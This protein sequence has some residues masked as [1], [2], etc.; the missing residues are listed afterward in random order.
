MDKINVCFEGSDDNDLDIH[1]ASLWCDAQGFF[2][3]IFRSY[4]I[5]EKILKGE[6]RFRVFRKMDGLG[7]FGYIL[8]LSDRD[9][10]NILDE[11]S[12]IANEWELDEN[13]LAQLIKKSTGEIYPI[14]KN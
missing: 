4:S 9:D 6:L 1:S 3:A 7:K 2:P 10:K 13:Q 8:G 11:D 5:K 14:E 12:T